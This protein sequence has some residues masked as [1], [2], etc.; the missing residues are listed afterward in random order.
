MAKQWTYRYDKNIINV[1]NSI[2]GEKLSI[3]GEVQDMRTG[4]TFRRVELKGKLPSGEEVRASL[5]GNWT[6]QCNLFVDN[7]LQA[8][9]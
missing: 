4:L 1:E 3:N 5:G 2:K 6:I 9:E 8:P 7:K